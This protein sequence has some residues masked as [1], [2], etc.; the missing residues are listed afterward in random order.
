M[1]KTTPKQRLRARRAPVGETRR[2]AAGD[3][4]SAPANRAAQTRLGGHDR[5]P[6]P[7]LARD[8]G[9]RKSERG[10]SAAYA[11]EIFRTAGEPSRAPVGRKLARKKIE[12]GI[13]GPGRGGACVNG[14][15]EPAGAGKGRGRY[16]LA[17]LNERELTHG[18]YPEMALIAQG[19]KGLLRSGRAWPRMTPQAREGLEQT[20]AKMARAVCGDPHFAEHYRDM[21]G[22]STLVADYLEGHEL[23]LPEL[24]A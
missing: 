3:A 7:P 14:A 19:I 24:G 17:L 21:A 20:A 16:N 6:P 23:A 12:V 5:D 4:A 22:Y 13:A 10:R 9:G 11:R 1:K 15:R 8:P 18:D 2:S